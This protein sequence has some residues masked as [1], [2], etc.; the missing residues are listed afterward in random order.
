VSVQ[1][2]SDQKSEAKF[3]DCLAL[4]KLRGSALIR[5]ITAVLKDCRGFKAVKKITVYV[6]NNQT[7]DLNEMKGNWN[8]WHKVA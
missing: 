5:Q 6:N 7:L 4:Y 1:R 8:L 3:T 2:L